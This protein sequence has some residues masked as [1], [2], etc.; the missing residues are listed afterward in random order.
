LTHRVASSGVFQGEIPHL[1]GVASCGEG[2]GTTTVASGL[3]MTLSTQ[4]EAKVLLIDGNFGSGAGHHMLGIT[5][6]TTLP[7]VLLDGQG[8]TSKV[9]EGLYLL[10]AGNGEHK[11]V[12]PSLGRRFREL[13]GFLK[14]GKYTSVVMDLPPITETSPTL[15]MAGLLDGVILV[16]ESEKTSRERA[17]MALKLL[18]G[19]NANV[20]GVV[21][22]KKRDYVPDWL[23]QNG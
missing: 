9:Q 16:V 1:I 6:A 2:A 3:A 13:V 20:L 17:R 11:L 23:D 14:Q 5:S 15:Q 18:H 21:F 19:A 22:N 8:R 7:Q 4:D 10:A 12:R